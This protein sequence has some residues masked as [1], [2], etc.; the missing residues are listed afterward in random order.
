MESIIKSYILK[1]G[2]DFDFVVDGVWHEFETEKQKGWYIGSEKTDGKIVFSFGD[3]RTGDQF[4]EKFGWGEGDDSWKDTLSEHVKLEQA[5]R[6]EW[7]ESARHRANRTYGEMATIGPSPYLLKKGFEQTPKGVKTTLNRFGRVDLVVP[8]YD[9]AKTDNDRLGL[10]LWNLQSIQE[11]SFKIF[12]EGGQTKGVFHIVGGFESLP[13][14]EK[15]YICEGYSTALSVHMADASAVTV[16]AFSLNNLESIV[17]KF[18]DH[19]SSAQIILC[20][21]DDRFVVH[22]KTGKPWNPGRERSL[23]IAKKHNIDIL[24]PEFSKE[25]RGSDFNDMMKNRGLEAITKLLSN[26]KALTE[27]KKLVKAHKLPTE[28]GESEAE[29]ARSLLLKYFEHVTRN[30]KDFFKWT[31]T[32]WR[33]LDTQRVEW[34]IQQAALEFYGGKAKLKWIDPIIKLIRMQFPVAPKTNNLYSASP[35]LFNFTDGTYEVRQN[36]NGA[37]DI[38]KREHRMDD[39]LS[40][41]SPF[42]YN[43]EIPRDLP[44]SGIFLKY[45]EA[46]REGLG[47]EGI[48]VLKQMLGAALLPYSPRF[49]FLLGESD[50]GKSTFAFLM[51]QLVGDENCSF[52]DPTTWKERFALAPMLGKLCN[53]VTE[54]PKN[55]VVKDDVMKKVRDRIPV[56]VERK[57]RDFENASI[58]PIH[59]FCCNSLPKSLEGN[60]GALDNRVTILKFKKSKLEELNVYDLGSHIWRTDAYTVL[61][62]AREGLTDLIT[63]DLRYH[64]PDA[65]RTH[66]Q[67]WQEENDPVRLWLYALEH[68]EIKYQKVETDP[69]KPEPGK[70]IYQSFV[71]W[72]D[73][74]GFQRMSSIRFYKEV[75]RCGVATFRRGKGGT[76]V[77]LPESFKLDAASQ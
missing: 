25:E 17:E 48:R 15:I 47:D 32:H 8:M 58:P 14:M 13:L 40:Y 30:G 44:R 61:Q 60:S 70:A 76:K 51:K 24:F 3:W 35:Y 12:I 26:K 11:D 68:G 75:E 53:I 71:E 67:E 37:R 21:D 36:E 56:G 34:Q 43:G 42:P 6:Q 5:R 23:S 65:S 39:F 16:C 1:L 41:C 54:L 7:A 20:A 22:P 10:E 69:E 18:K 62:C 45:L 4:S 74:N 38:I 63:H 46:K 72:C 28:D 59:V 9:F 19:F 2:Y 57:G 52:V 55:A 49:F 31:G 50:S 66:V 29:I 33:M 73:N 27:T 77:R 64:V